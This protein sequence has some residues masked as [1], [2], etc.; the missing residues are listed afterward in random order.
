MQQGYSIKLNEFK[1]APPQPKKK[2]TQPYKYIKN[3]F[4]YKRINSFI[5]LNLGSS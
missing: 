3:Q 1:A 2:K 4:P 5:L